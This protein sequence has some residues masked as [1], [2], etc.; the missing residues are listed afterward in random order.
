MGG[1]AGPGGQ[2]GGVRVTGGMGGGVAGPDMVG[3]GVR[4]APGSGGGIGGATGSG[5]AQVRVSP[6]S[7]EAANINQRIELIMLELQQLKR[8]IARMQR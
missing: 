6:S 4:I 1:L 5:T 8:D 3:G 7:A 2:G